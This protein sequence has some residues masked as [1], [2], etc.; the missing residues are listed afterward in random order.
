MAAIEG[1]YATPVI[2]WY[3]MTKAGMGT[4]TRL[5]EPRPARARPGGPSP[6]RTC[7]SSERTGPRLRVGEV[8]E[9]VF[10]TDVTGFQGYLNDDEATRSAVTGRVVPRRRHGIFRRRRVLLLR[11][12]QEGHR[13]PGRGE[14]LEPR[15]RIGDPHP[16]GR[17]R[18]GGGGPS[19]TRSWASGWWRS[20]SLRRARASRRSR[21]CARSP[22]AP[23]PASR[24]SEEIY[25]V[26]VLP[27]TGTGKVEKFRLHR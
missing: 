17:G 15:G 7:T 19:R 24:G 26:D 10:N 23:W 14:Y 20:S 21:I 11:R 18:C 27:R 3:G 22:R 5:G 6:G 12:P 9:V 16:S 13:A 1:R 25:E 2:D 4:Y 8:G